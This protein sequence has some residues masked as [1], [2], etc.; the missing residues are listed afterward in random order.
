MAFVSWRAGFGVLVALCVIAVSASCP[1]LVI[2]N[3]PFSVVRV[4]EGKTAAEV[5]ADN[6]PPRIWVSSGRCPFRS[7]VMNLVTVRDYGPEN[8]PVGR[9]VTLSH[10]RPELSMKTKSDGKK[11]P[12]EHDPVVAGF[13]DWLMEDARYEKYNFFSTAFEDYMR[14]MEAGEWKAFVTLLENDPAAAEQELAARLSPDGAKD[15]EAVAEARKMVAWLKNGGVSL[16]DSFTGAFDLWQ[17]NIEQGIWAVFRNA[18]RKGD[19]KMAKTILME[20]YSQPW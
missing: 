16:C 4:P 3:A 18:A 12:V 6:S 11:W 2:S 8:N 15:A 17:K 19:L 13:Y 1:A 9:I 5:L 10:I 14:S 20:H 7:G